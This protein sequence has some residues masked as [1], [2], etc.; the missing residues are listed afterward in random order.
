MKSPTTRLLFSSVFAIGLFFP[1]HAFATRF[2][3]D[4]PP[5]HPAFEA[6]SELEERGVINGFSDGS[7]RPD[8]TIT[9]AAALK[10]VLLSAGAEMNGVVSISP[11]PDVPTGEWFAPIARKGKELGIVQG[12]AQGNFL[13]SKNVSRAEALAMLF[14]TQ[15]T[16]LE[17]PNESPFSDVSLS[18]WYA[19]HF[20]EAKNRGL[21][22][23]N[24]ANP[25]ALLTR[26]ELAD[27]AFRFFQPTWEESELRGQASYYG[28]GLEGGGTASG[29]TFSN[30]EF[31]AAHRTLPFGTRVRVI[32]PDTLA[33]VVVKIVDRGPFVSG[34]VIDL[35]QAA[36][37]VLAP[38]SQG[39]TD[40]KLEVVPESTP[41]GQTPPCN[42]SIEKVEFLPEDAFPGIELLGKTPRFFR[43]GE[44]VHIAGRF[45]EQ[46]PPEEITAF[47]E[48]DGVQQTFRG[49]ISGT[50]FA[51]D[52]FFPHAG[53]FSLAILLGASGSAKTT[54]V[55][56]VEENCRIS[57]EENKNAPTNLRFEIRNGSTHFQWDGNGN[58]LFRIEFSQGNK[59]VSFFR[60]KEQ[61][62]LPPPIAL[63]DFQEGFIDVRL[64]GAQADDSLHQKGGWSASESLHTYA[65]KRVSREYNKLKDVQL[66]E[67][68]SLG[69][70]I[71]LSGTTPSSLEPTIA[72]VDPLENI[73]E[74]NLSFSGEHFSASFQPKF[75]GSYLVEIN[76]ADALTLFVGLVVPKG[77]APLLPD[78]FDLLIGRESKENIEDMPSIMLGMLNRE[79]R[80]RGI[81]ELSE[82][83][84]LNEL[85]QFRAQD[86]CDRQYFSHQDPDGKQAEDYRVLYGVQTTVGENIARNSSVFLAHEGLMRSPAHRKLII[87]TSYRQ[88][89][90]GFC[91]DTSDSEGIII[92]QIFGGDPYN[93]EKLSEWRTEILREAN[94]KRQQSPIVPN[95]I[96]EGVAQQWANRMSEK[97]LWGFSDGEDTLE[98]SLR[99]T[100]INDYARGMVLRIGSIS[101]LFGLFSENEIDLGEGIQENFLLDTRFDKM[102]IGVAQSKTWEIFVVILATES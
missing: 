7:F 29:E 51:V 18:A 87:D 90:L 80:D 84:A 19:P 49:E 5:T 44:V 36:F 1:N 101:Q 97:D 71:S 28:N 21:L 38:L 65:V 59:T 15:G 76:R 4:I 63:A 69:E 50:V 95:A 89:G 70:K 16:S 31:M 35:S 23:G 27:L 9:R 40:V 62:I 22:L 14:R 66:T 2:F 42:N 91:R 52:V 25:D 86:M 74:E 30:A 54:P 8:A 78:G 10:I 20:A 60:S 85:A 41:L 61:E 12:D 17:T 83:D 45:S 48:E 32:D 68:F 6:I 34:R 58:N 64:W 67:S 33:S 99:E 73:F 79:R 92:V 39:V 47:Y 46:N 102:G 81:P 96:L 55:N 11:F 94:E 37:Q 100:G 98:K 93:K 57:N 88:V 82:N 53:D 77:V 43:A 24:T 72:I 26:Q 75:S 13:P 56:V 3:T